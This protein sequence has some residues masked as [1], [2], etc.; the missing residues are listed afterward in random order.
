LAEEAGLEERAALNLL[1]GVEAERR[2]KEAERG[3]DVRLAVHG[4]VARPPQRDLRV[5][6]ANLRTGDRVASIY[7]PAFEDAPIDASAESRRAQE[8]GPR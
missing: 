2:A 8:N 3:L 5:D 4:R 7:Q 6:G 1:L